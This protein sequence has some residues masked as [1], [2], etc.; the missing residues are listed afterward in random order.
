LIFDAS[1]RFTASQCLRHSFFQC[2][3]ISIDAFNPIELP[4]DAF[5]HEKWKP[6]L[7][8]YKTE[9][10]KEGKMQTVRSFFISNSFHSL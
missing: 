1:K 2:Y 5:E 8:E 7:E 6:S 10:F 9:L 4:M 3:P